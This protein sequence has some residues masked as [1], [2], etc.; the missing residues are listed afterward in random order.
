MGVTVSSIH[1]WRKSDSMNLSSG[2]SPS[3][4]KN[5]NG[6]SNIGSSLWK[7]IVHLPSLHG[8]H[9][10]NHSIWS[11]STTLRRLKDEATQNPG[12]KFLM[13][14]R[15]HLIDYEYQKQKGRCSQ[16]SELSTIVKSYII[17]SDRNSRIRELYLKICPSRSISMKISY[18]STS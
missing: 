16:E 1:R 14:S 10:S 6:C 8:G 2:R 12:T 4:M 13:L 5:Q 3:R 15:R 9:H 17:V 11:R 18:V 7:N